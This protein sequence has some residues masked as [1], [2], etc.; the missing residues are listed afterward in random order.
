MAQVI[1]VISVMFIIFNI[2]NITTFNIMMITHHHLRPGMSWEE[3]LR[4]HF[5]VIDSLPGDSRQEVRVLLLIR[6][7]QGIEIGSKMTIDKSYVGLSQGGLS[8]GQRRNPELPQQKQDH[9]CKVK[10]STVSHLLH[11]HV[12]VSMVSMC[13]VKSRPI[14]LKIA[15]ILSGL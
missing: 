7:F 4:E 10:P 2:T 8:A 14:Y 11:V 1:I 12:L 5:N 13:V 3:E 15:N 9:G 6:R